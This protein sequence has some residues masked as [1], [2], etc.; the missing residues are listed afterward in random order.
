[1]DYQTIPSDL[2]REELD[3]LVNNLAIQE[4]V[5][6]LIDTN[7][8][9]FLVGE[10]G[11]TWDAYYWCQY[12]FREAWTEQHDKNVLDD[13]A[14][15]KED[16]LRIS[17]HS[18][19]SELCLPYQMNIYSIS[20]KS[21]KYPPFEDILWKY[22]RISKTNRGGGYRHPNCRHF[23][24][25]YIEGMSFDDL[26]ERQLSEE[27]IL[28]NYDKRQQNNYNKRMAKNWG[29]KATYY[30]DAGLKEKAKKARDK[31]AFYNKRVN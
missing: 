31:R 2:D 18:D 20:G 27:Q 26:Y 6:E 13:A 19:C 14:Y 30:D 16:L 28:N 1:M 8:L 25:I 24:S 4:T 23:H 15:L 29:D 11:R 9:A 10:N 22:D 12:K 3:E 21:K 17:Y 5:T 7:R